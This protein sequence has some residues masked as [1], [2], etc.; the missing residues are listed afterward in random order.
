MD[1][2]SSVSMYD[3]DDMLLEEDDLDKKS[4]TTTTTTATKYLNHV[5]FKSSKPIEQI[6]LDII[7]TYL[8]NPKQSG[9]G[10][11]TEYN[12]EPTERKQ[13]TVNYENKLFKQRVLAKGILK[14][15]DYIFLVNE[16]L[17]EVNY[18]FDNQQL[19][20]KNIDDNEDIK[21]VQI[22]AE[23]LVL[24]DNELNDVVQINK[25]QLFKNV[26]YVKFKF[27]FD[28]EQCRRRLER[29]STLH[30]R[31]IELLQAFQTNTIVFR[32]QP[33]SAFSIDKIEQYFINNKRKFTEYPV[34][35]MNL[36]GQFLL[37]KFK[38]TQLMLDFINDKHRHDLFKNVSY[39]KLF[40]FDLII[41]END[42]LNNTN[43]SNNNSS[44]NNPTSGDTNES[45]NLDI[46][47]LEE[48]EDF[49][50]KTASKFN[51][52]TSFFNK[53]TRLKD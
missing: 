22:F 49:F 23:T 21:V 34:A 40:N 48:E 50:S 44:I 37:I 51:F 39:E 31:K 27:E 16:P 41:D 17:Y 12:L 5:E 46:N 11:I 2:H 10:N 35:S 32:F 30:D 15:Q 25:S 14:F 13:L 36:K 29:R 24:N 9:G 4:D 6:D 7:V 53:F 1:T 38:S 19:I 47:N 52:V 42:D 8:E 3:V 28:W 43:N 45:A 26:F 20:L 18:K 33:N